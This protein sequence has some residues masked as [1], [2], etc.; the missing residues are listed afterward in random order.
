MDQ[1]ISTFLIL[2]IMLG[3]WIGD[4]VLQP[5]WMGENKS[6]H[7]SIL[8]THAATYGCFLFVWTLLVT[9]T[10]GRFDRVYTLVM[11]ASNFAFM[12][13][14]LHGI[15]DAITSRITHWMWDKKR[16]WGFFTII[17]LDQFIHFAC[18]LWAAQSHLVNFVAT[19]AT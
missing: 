12:S 17:G 2:F 9:W 7:L 18:L 1:T 16:V 5:R 10:M 6:K 4:F 14:V 13:M 15:V 3:H 11:T 19:N 8:L